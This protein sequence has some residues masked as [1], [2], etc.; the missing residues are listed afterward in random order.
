MLIYNVHMFLSQSKHF[1]FPVS[2][3]QFDHSAFVLGSFGSVMR[4]CWNTFVSKK[5]WK[6]N[7]FTSVLASYFVHIF[8]L[9]TH[10]TLFGV[11][12]CICLL[13]HQ[14][15]CLCQWE[16]VTYDTVKQLPH[17]GTHRHL[18]GKPGGLAR[19]SHRQQSLLL[20]S[21]KWWPWTNLRRFPWE[22][23]YKTLI[24]QKPPSLFVMAFF[25]RLT[26]H[27]NA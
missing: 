23:P 15:T 2:Y 20:T 7:N 3:H 27:R 10:I 21:F 16:L 5:S 1:Q 22:I 24:W 25:L 9:L 18:C 12:L 13:A 6:P 17:T 4:T 8:F 11:A 14:F 26:G 19:L